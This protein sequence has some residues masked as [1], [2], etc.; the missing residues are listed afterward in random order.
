MR[1]LKIMQIGQN[2]L[3][4]GVK[5]NLVRGPKKRGY[6]I[7]LIFASL[8]ISQSVPKSLQSTCPCLGRTRQDYSFEVLTQIVSQALHKSVLFQVFKLG[9]ISFFWFFKIFRI[10]CPFMMF[11]DHDTI[12]LAFVVAKKKITLNYYIF[13][14]FSE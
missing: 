7:L 14:N 4:R 1:W 3:S 11:C 12:V 5:I 6:H 10:K 13:V 9:I 2:K 8:F